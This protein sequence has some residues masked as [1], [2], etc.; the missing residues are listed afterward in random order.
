MLLGASWA[1]SIKKK[2]TFSTKYYIALEND[3]RVTF[4]KVRIK[5]RDNEF[6]TLLGIKYYR[7]MSKRLNILK[8][9]VYNVSER[10]SLLTF[11]LYEYYSVRSTTEI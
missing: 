6:S 5:N 10:I 1:S 11:L 2:I 4:H 3:N 8:F 7:W 9:E